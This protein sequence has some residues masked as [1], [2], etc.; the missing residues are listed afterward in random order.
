MFHLQPKVNSRNIVEAEVVAKIVEV[1]VEVIAVAKNEIQ[2]GRK[3]WFKSE[4]FL[5]P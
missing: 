2:N 5:R 3:E 4:E 1:V